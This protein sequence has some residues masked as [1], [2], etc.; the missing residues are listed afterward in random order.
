MTLNKFQK[1]NESIRLDGEAKER[2]IANI[3]AADTEPVRRRWFSPAWAGVFCGA[4]VLVLFLMIPRST[5]APMMEYSAEESVSDSYEMEVTEETAEEEK[6][7]RDAEM[8]S[9][10]LGYRVPDF[11]LL[12]GAEVEYERTGESSGLAVI[13]HEGNEYV[14]YFT[15]KE[16]PSGSTA[17]NN[18]F[19]EDGGESEPAVQFTS[20]GI[21]YTVSSRNPLSEEEIELLKGIIE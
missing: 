9:E 6:G 10:Q 5:N 2:M 8:L 19:M 13:H 1:A 21:E 17:E 16:D 4:L 7:M 11:G 20:D 12:E 15:P 18:T 3:L 14:V